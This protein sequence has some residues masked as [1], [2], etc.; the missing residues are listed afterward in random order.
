MYVG[1][2]V[3]EVVWCDCDYGDVCFDEFGDG[4]L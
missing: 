4:R 2:V 1:N 3:V